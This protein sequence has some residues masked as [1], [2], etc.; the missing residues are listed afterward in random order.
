MKQCVP[1]YQVV[2][3]DGDVIDLGFPANN[4]GKKK[5]SSDSSSREN[6]SRSKMN[7][8]EENG[9]Q[10]WDEYMRCTAA[11][12]DCG[13]P[14]FIEERLDLVSFPAFIVEALRDGAK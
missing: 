6:Q 1:A 7:Q 11:F 13:L 8:W 5:G 10:K 3:D 12:L 2:F 4:D 14:N 9:A